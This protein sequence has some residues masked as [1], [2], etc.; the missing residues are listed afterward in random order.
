[1][2]LSKSSVAPA[3]GM[4]DEQSSCCSSLVGM[5]LRGQWGTELR[6]VPDLLLAQPAVTFQTARTASGHVFWCFTPLDLQEHPTL[7]SHLL[8]LTRPVLSVLRDVFSL[9]HSCLSGA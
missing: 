7:Q 5:G 1:M 9:L 2:I 3:R 8:Q 6:S 4:E